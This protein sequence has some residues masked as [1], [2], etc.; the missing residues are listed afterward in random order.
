MIGP[1]HDG[2]LAALG[3]GLP[4]LRDVLGYGT[5]EGLA[6]P[7]AVLNL[8]GVEPADEP[9]DGSGRLAVRCRWELFLV[10]A[11]RTPGVGRK[12]RELAGASAALV[13][14]NRFGLAAPPARFVL[15]EP[16]EFEPSWKGA[17]SWRVEFE[18]VVYLGANVWDGEGVMPE[19][20]LVSHTPLIGLE[21]EGEYEEVPG[22]F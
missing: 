6:T 11:S 14:G 17:E 19:T 3:Q 4:G 22:E 18:Q 5:A 16:N 9:E 21:H 2:I 20:V 13:Q 12:L 8:A 10:M 1:A 15:A 7:A